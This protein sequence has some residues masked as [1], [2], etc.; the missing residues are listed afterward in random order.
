[1]IAT[2]SLKNKKTLVQYFQ[3][4]GIF[5]IEIISF[6]QLRKAKLTGKRAQAEATQPMA[7][8]NFRLF[9]LPRLPEDEIYQSYD[10]SKELFQTAWTT[11]KGFPKYPD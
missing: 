4:H 6:D 8:Y 10:I 1:M 11:K 2:D 7:S 5:N 3:N 9:K